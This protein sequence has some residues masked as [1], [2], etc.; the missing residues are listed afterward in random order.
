MSEALK[1][2][3]GLQ[4]LNMHC[5]YQ[6]RYFNNSQTVFHRSKH[7]NRQQDRKIW[8]NRIGSIVAHQFHTHRSQYE[9]YAQKDT[10]PPEDNYP[11]FIYEQIATS[12]AAKLF[13][14]LNH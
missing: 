5:E 3:G 4:K 1:I 2:N 13:Q 12:I 8:D 9:L 11:L 14:C 7:A 6:T 10:Y